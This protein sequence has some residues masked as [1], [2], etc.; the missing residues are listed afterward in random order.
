MNK[1]VLNIALTLLIISFYTTSFCQNDFPTISNLSN[2]LDTKGQ[3]KIGKHE[4]LVSEDMWKKC[5][6]S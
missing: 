4:P 5:Q 3:E 6:I 1:L 2:N